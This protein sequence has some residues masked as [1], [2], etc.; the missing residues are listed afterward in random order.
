MFASTW[1]RILCKRIG[2]IASFGQHDFLKSLVY[3]IGFHVYQSGF[4]CLR[5][6]C[7]VSPLLFTVACLLLT[8][9]I[10]VETAVNSARKRLA[11]AML[12]MILHTLEV[13]AMQL[14]KLIH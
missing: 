10:V 8:T 13:T 4:H 6:W 5:R 3:K 11:T 1:K 12:S 7:S 9:T 2:L 14:L